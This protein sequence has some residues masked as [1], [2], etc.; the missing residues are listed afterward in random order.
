MI[1]KRSDFKK[2]L[3]EQKQKLSN[4]EK[5]RLTNKNENAFGFGLKIATDF[6][7]TIIVGCLIGLGI[8]K[9]F[10]TKPI[11]F[12][13]FFTFGYCRS[14]SKYISYCFKIK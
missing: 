3:F 2:N 5:N 9:L 7:V 12:F 13:N 10:Q 11:F 8:D 14:F 4:I 1:D 6:I